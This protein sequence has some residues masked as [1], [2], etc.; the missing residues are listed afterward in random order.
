MGNINTKKRNFKTELRPTSKFLSGIFLESLKITRKP[1]SKFKPFTFS[2]RLHS[3]SKL[4]SRLCKQ[5][6]S[7]TSGGSL[8]RQKNFI[9]FYVRRRT[10]HPKLCRHILLV[11]KKNVS[12]K[13]TFT[14]SDYVRTLDSLHMVLHPSGFLPSTAAFILASEF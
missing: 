6:V 11:L 1:S 3:H 8:G 2:V 13:L 4:F 7:I 9:N 14:T 5:V 12:A 10:Y